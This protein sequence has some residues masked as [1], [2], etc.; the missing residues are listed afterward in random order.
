MKEDCDFDDGFVD[1][2]AGEEC[3]FDDLTNCVEGDDMCIENG[4]TGCGEC[5]FSGDFGGD[6]LNNCQAQFGILG[7]CLPCDNCPFGGQSTQEFFVYSQEGVGDPS[8]DCEN[9]HNYVECYTQGYSYGEGDPYEHCDNYYTFVPQ[10]CYI[11]LEEDVPFFDWF[12]IVF[13]LMILTSYYLSNRKQ[14]VL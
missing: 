8:S 13:G 2:D 12:S 9:G 7:E 3:D 6:S 11:T 1:G 4:V 14:K 10:D 5:A